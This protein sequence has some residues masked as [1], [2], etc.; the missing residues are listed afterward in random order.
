L[1]DPG[2]LPMTSAA[3]RDVRPG[4]RPGSA[5]APAP[6]WSTP[7]GRARTGCAEPVDGRDPAGS[8]PAGGPAPTA[9]GPGHVVAT[10]APT[11]RYRRPCGP[12]PPAIPSGLRPALPAPRHVAPG[13]PAGRP[14]YVHAAQSPAPVAP[15]APSAGP[16]ARPARGP[17]APAPAASRPGAIPAGG[18]ARAMRPGAARPRPGRIVAVPVRPAATRSP[19]GGPARQPPGHHPV[20]SAASLDPANAR[21]GSPP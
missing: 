5:D 17:V 7:V 18:S 2:L 15:G 6:G 4:V 11:G 20:G 12:T 8:A 3:A 10:A 9:R 19:A 16:S 21:P 14:G 13:Y 1:Q